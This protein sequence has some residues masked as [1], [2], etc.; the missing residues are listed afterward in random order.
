MLWTTTVCLIPAMPNFLV[1]LSSIFR[2]VGGGTYTAE[3]LLVTMLVRTSKGGTRLRNLYI[4]YMAFALAEVVGMLL[5]AVAPK[6]S[7]WLPI[8]LGLGALFVCFLVVAAIPETEITAQIT[9]L[10]DN[11]EGGTATRLNKILSQIRLQNS[12]IALPMLYA[13]A[14]RMA[15]QG[16][17]AGPA[18]NISE[19]SAL[20]LIEIMPPA[21][22]QVRSLCSLAKS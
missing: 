8:G 5:S 3:I 15:V 21:N 14:L 4:M 17:S 19:V 2:L 9:S 6:I 18:L 1:W 12:H 7:I 20:V 13:A 16:F 11:Q 10:V 22:S